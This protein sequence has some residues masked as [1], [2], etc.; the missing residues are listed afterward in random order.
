MVEKS[1]TAVGHGD[2]WWPGI[3]A[4]IRGVGQKIANFFAPD[5]DA[6]ATDESYE[7]SIE[8]P[9]VGAEDIDV[10]VN[11]NTLTIKGEKKSE[12]EEKGKTHYFS[13]R[14]YGAFER[15][16]RLPDNAVADHISADFKDGVLNLKIPKRGPSADTSRKIPVGRSSS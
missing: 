4:P 11:E 3:Y 13:E 6:A 8:L 7:I 14:T 10:S 12:H 9:G 16:F 2:A 1:H 15:S 5:A